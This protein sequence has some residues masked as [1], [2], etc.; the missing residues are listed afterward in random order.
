MASRLRAA[1]SRLQR[2]P[3]RL[4][5]ATGSW[6]AGKE[7]REARG[8]DHRW[9]RYRLGYLAQHPL[10]VMCHER[11]LVAVATVV[12]HIVPH[13]GDQQLFWLE[14]NHQALCKACHDGDKARQER[15]QG[16]R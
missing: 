9:R 3:S 5:V 12:D 6:R 1:P 2:A 16:L 8:Y 7:S 4:A 10:C 15:K 11:G 14:T 13:R